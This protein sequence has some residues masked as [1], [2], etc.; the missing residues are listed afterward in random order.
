MNLALAYRGF[1]KRNNK[2]TN[3]FNLEIFKNHLDS[4]NTLNIQNIDIYIHTYSINECEDKKLLS[5][6]ENYNLKKYIFEEKIR[7][8]ISYS[9]INSLELVDK[10]YDLI[11]NTRFDVYFIK[12]LS[13]W[14]IN[15]NKLNLAFKDI[16]KS[17]VRK[18]KVSDLIY[19]FPKKYNNILISALKKSTN[20]V[21]SSPGHF[22]YKKLNID[23]NEIN[24]MI[25][26][27]FSSNTDSQP[28]NYIYIKRN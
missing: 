12:Y 1:Y 9:I 11:I 16:K 19:I 13:D 24:F 21:N 5:I 17:W 18:K 23:E 2:K 6:F 3:N 7:K 15:Y 4:I 28:N 20:V 22:I 25:D 27:F 14:S 8:K 10:N 26:G